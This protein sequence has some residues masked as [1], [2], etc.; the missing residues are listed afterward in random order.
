MRERLLLCLAASAMVLAA[1]TGSIPD[2][3][4]IG[5]EQYSMGRDPRTGEALQ[6]LRVAVSTS[7]VGR[8]K[9]IAEDVVKQV[10]GAYYMIIVRIYSAGARPGEA[11]AEQ[12]FIWSRGRGLRKVRR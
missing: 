9:A 8:A 1:C 11:R 4:K 12:I 10:G 5:E 2:Y 3:E 7:D 6:G